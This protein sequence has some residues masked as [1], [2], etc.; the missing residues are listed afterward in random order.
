MTTHMTFRVSMLATLVLFIGAC[1]TNPYVSKDSRSTGRLSNE[2]VLLHSS[3]EPLPVEGGRVMTGNDAA[4]HSKLELIK[5]AKTS[6]DAMYYIYSDDFSSSVLT[7]AL[8]DAAVRGVRVR[9]LLDY[10]TNY[11]DLDL[12]SMMEKYGNKGKG[13]LEVRLYNRPTHAIVQD[14]VYLTLGC[15]EALPKTDQ[16]C[17]LAKNRQIDDLFRNEQVAGRP[18]AELGIS[19]LNIGNSG[20]FLSGLYSKKADL[21]ALAVLTGQSIDLVSLK[22]SGEAPSA[23]ERA[24]LKKVATIYAQ[25]RLGSPFERL[26]SKIQLALLSGLYGDTLDPMHEAFTGYLPVER[27]SSKQAARDWDYFTDYLHHKLLLVDQHHVQL[28]GRNV[29]DSYHMRQNPLTTKYVFM[30]T[31]VRVDLSSPESTLQRAF[32]ALWNF[33]VMVATLADVATR[34]Q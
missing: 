12:L 17:G 26:T 4:F 2:T 7:E 29:E 25:T 3:S 33:N 14:A 5:S 21:V 6:I 15:G 23:Q 11:N 18:A 1:S 31:D 30:D 10:A 20:L 28:G 27:P 34:A 13:S 8:I 19:N 22:Q 9:L 32:E 16:Q 24:Q